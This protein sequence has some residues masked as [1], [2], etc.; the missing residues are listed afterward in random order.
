MS[1]L[2]GILRVGG[3]LGAQ[4]KH[5]RLVGDS[6]ICSE[7]APLDAEE[8]ARVRQQADEVAVTQDGLPRFHCGLAS[9][10]GA[11]GELLPLALVRIARPRTH[12]LD[13]Q[14]PSVVRAEEDGV[15]QADPRVLRWQVQLRL[16]RIFAWAV[17]GRERERRRR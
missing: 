12:V 10:S 15:A 16:Q 5:A 6:P 8:R 7:S 17:P 9:A 1:Q 14:I 3:I 13:I 2:S 4:R 11:E